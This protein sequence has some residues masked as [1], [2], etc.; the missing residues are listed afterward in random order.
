VDSV[1]KTAK[2]L[3]EALKLALNELGVAEENVDY[4][5]LEQGVKGILGFGSKPFKIK[6]TKKFDPVSICKNFLREIFICMGIIVEFDIKEKERHI[7]I[8]LKGSEMG[9]LIG[10]RGQTLDSLQYLVNLA[11]NKGNAP[12]VSVTL[13][14]ENYRE[15]RKE[16]LENLA[17]NLAKIVKVTRKEVSL[18]PMN[19]YERR[20]IH[21]SLQNDRFVST[22]SQGQEPFRYVVI[23][24]KERGKKVQQ[25]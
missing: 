6:V 23:S 20:I 2:T 1:E 22:F 5:V 18:E 12:Y 9:V 14:A 3:E 13:D 10:K 11:V 21:S 15:R 16:T 17:H 25:A 4:V 8:L 24:P 19:P 7:D